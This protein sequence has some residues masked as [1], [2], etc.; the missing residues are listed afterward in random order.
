MIHDVI[1]MLF[2]GLEEKIENVDFLHLSGMTCHSFQIS[3][4]DIKLLDSSP[5]G[6]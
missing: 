4:L 5:S 3:S 2:K 6:I 1:S